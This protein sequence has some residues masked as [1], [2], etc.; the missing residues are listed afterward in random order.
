MQKRVAFGIPWLS[1]LN[2]VVEIIPDTDTLAA[3]HSRIYEELQ[4]AQ[5]LF[6][7]FEKQFLGVPSALL[8]TIASEAKQELDFRSVVE[9]SS[10]RQ[11]EFHSL[12]QEATTK[13]STG[14]G[15]SR[16]KKARASR[17]S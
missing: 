13:V 4:N 17:K 1:S 16:G 2:N 9:A 14:K 11:A 12:V 7:H 10:P 6:S 15:R 5:E 8:D 3:T